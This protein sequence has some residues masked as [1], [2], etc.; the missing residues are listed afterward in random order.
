MNFEDATDT[1][2]AALLADGHFTVRCGHDYGH[3]IT[4]SEYNLAVDWALAHSY[5]EPSP[6]ESTGIDSFGDWCELAQ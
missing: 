3:T 5:G 4:M 1:L 2:Q 6:Y